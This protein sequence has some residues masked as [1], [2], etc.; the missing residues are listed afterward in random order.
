M[1][2]EKKKNRSKAFLP[3]FILEV[4][5]MLFLVWEVFYYF[6]DVSTEFWRF[7]FVDV[8]NIIAQIATAGVFYLGF[9]QYHRNKKL[10]RQAVLI[11]EC[12]GVVVKMVSIIKEFN[13]GA[14]TNFEN[15]KH[16]CGRLGGLGSDF[17]ELF[18]EIDENVHKGI[19]RMHWQSMYFNEFVYVMEKLELGGAVARTNI[20]SDKYAYSLV[21]ARS[22][23]RQDGVL[24]VHS[25]YYT[26]LGVL[27]DEDIKRVISVFEFSDLFMFVLYFFE[28]K[29]TDDYMYG[30]ISKLDVKE[31]APLI[32]AISGACG[33][34]YEVKK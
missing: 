19:V 4:I 21:S 20:P 33:F 10:E 17:Q 14:N 15:I 16:C 8:V 22:K 32:A 7:K 12:K 3:L 18:S 30:S 28:S 26:F 6:I 1:L 24:E 31:R 25:K 34:N 11:D 23:S 29:Y 2:Y 27:S 9:H 5:L 13:V